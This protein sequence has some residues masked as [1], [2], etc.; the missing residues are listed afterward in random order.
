MKLAFLLLLGAIAP[1]AAAAAPI[2]S[3]PA[4]ILAS[5]APA[6]RISGL[7]PG[8][9]IRVHALRRVTVAATDKQPERPV[10]V[11]AWADFVADR[12][13]S[14][15]PGEVAPLAG[16]WTGADPLGLM[17]SGWPLGD[18]RLAGVSA[19]GLGADTLS[20]NRALLVTLELDGRRQPPQR[21]ALRPSDAGLDIIDL[22]VAADGVSGVLAIPRDGKRPLPAIIQLH[23][24]EGGSMAG[25]RSRAI[26]L[27]SRGYAVLAL[28]YVSYAYGSP[29][30]AGVPTTFANLPVELLDRARLALTGRPGIDSRRIALVGGSKGAEFALV[31]ASHYPW[32]KAVV[33]CVPSDI[34]WSGFGRA[35]EPGE[36]LSSWSIAGKSLPAVD[37]DRYEDVFSG[38]ASAAEVHRRSR[39][40]ASAT[41]L[42]RARIP[43]ENI[44]APVLLLG[45]GK[46]EVW[47]SAEMATA[48]A[49]TLRRARGAKAVELATFADA[50]HGI[51]GTGASPVRAAGQDDAATAQ[52]AGIAFRRTLAF[53]NRTL[54]TTN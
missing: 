18:A 37:Y 30:I 40:L 26:T 39:A 35:A 17:W 11:H 34:V 38:K 10:V 27:A 48:V 49:A 29:G 36:M 6:L 31:G 7:T 19:E 5:E 51:C 44:R 3:A 8:S 2:L 15:S 22:T 14:L 1:S 50:G 20:D 41:L 28:N 12:S 24:S 25:A 9:K 4:E 23:G 54:R 33:G 53:L 42:R 32:V 46:D 52:A 13:G 45:S 16:S 47:Q 21:I 43:V